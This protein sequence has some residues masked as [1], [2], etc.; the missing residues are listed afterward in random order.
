M[1]RPKLTPIE[2]E[3]SKEKRRIQQ[4]IRRAKKRGFI[5]PIT[6]IETPKN[7]S[8]EDVLALQSITPEK[9]YAQS[10][11]KDIATG[12]IFS[13]LQGR[14]IERH[15]S[16]AKSTETRYGTFRTKKEEPY[17]PHPRATEISKQYTKERQRIKAFLK[18]AEKRGYIFP[19]NILEERPKNI[20]L[21]DLNRLK[22]LRPEQLYKQGYYL[23]NP[24]TGEVISGEKGRDIERKN[25]AQKA[26]ETREEKRQT[27]NPE[28]SQLPEPSRNERPEPVLSDTVLKRM[29]EEID[30]WDANTGWTVYTKNQK[31]RDRGKAKALLEMAES[32]YG[33]DGL[34]Q[35]AEE[36]AN[37]LI[38][39]L[40]I[41]LYDSDGKNGAVSEGFN[42]FISILFGHGLSMD[43][44]AEIEERAQ[45]LYYFSDDEL[46]D[47]NQNRW[48]E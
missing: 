22:S 6:K 30:R 42:Q 47:I 12:E 34:A 40:E 1:A 28:E 46:D 35:I 45:A 26:Q 43:E 31:E 10:K 11:Y 27:I 7:I 18:R 20:T 5:L 32:Q 48:D 39:Y 44:S 38:Y 33:R 16:H 2:K 15:R 13:G 17:I 36:N 4:I 19:D 24:D 25:S 3:F 23:I 41:I 9:I 14:A 37:E 8:K 29:E 21:S